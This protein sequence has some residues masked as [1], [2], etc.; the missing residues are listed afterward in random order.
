[1]PHGLSG[2]AGMKILNLGLTQQAAMVA[3]INIFW[4]LGILCIAIIPLVL[5]LKIPLASPAPAQAVAA[6]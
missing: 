6:E 2:A 4:L 3:F 5:F 1:M